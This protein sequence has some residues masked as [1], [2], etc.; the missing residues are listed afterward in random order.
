[1]IS[2]YVVRFEVVRN[3]RPFTVEV[4][5]QASGD[6]VAIGRARAVDTGAAVTL[7][8]WEHRAAVNLVKAKHLR[9]A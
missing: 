5:A 2:K 4:D 6:A 8:E 3:Q 1:M 9:G 7:N